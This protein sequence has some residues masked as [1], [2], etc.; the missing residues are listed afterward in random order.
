MDTRPGD[1]W[2]ECHAVVT[3]HPVECGAVSLTLTLPEEILPDSGKVG[4]TFSGGRDKNP[5]YVGTRDSNYRTQNTSDVT[6]VRRHCSPWKIEGPGLSLPGL[7]L[8]RPAPSVTHYV[9]LS[10]KDTV[11]NLQ[12]DT[13][14]GWVPETRISDGSSSEDS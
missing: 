14:R 7:T 6:L 13:S 10:G 12:E 1:P 9:R 2:E 3:H 11:T 5:V 8:R 4:T